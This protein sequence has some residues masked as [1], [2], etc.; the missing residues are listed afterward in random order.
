MDVSREEAKETLAA[1][2]QAAAQM[3]R[4]IAH[5]SSPYYM[6]L[7]GAIWFVGYICSHFITD[8][9]IGWIWLSLTG[10]GTLASAL[11]GVRIQTRLRTAGDKRYAYLWLS[12]IA[13][14]I[15]FIWI[16][17]PTVGEQASLLLVIFLMFGYVVM[18]IWLY[19]SALWVGLL[20]TSLALI[21]YYLFL[22]Y[23]YLWMAFLGGGT[24][25]ASGLFILRRWR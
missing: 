2:Q 6:I 13:Y 15:L 22:S 23:F 5:S 25:I 20:I 11:L 18:G 8:I 24:L 9:L 19:R 16:A 3:R 10:L 7:W 4:T 14:S 1:I 21:G 12:I 17:K